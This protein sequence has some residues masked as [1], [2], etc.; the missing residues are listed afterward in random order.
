MKKFFFLVT[1]A[2]AALA[3]VGQIRHSSNPLTVNGNTLSTIQNDWPA[4]V[5]PPDCKE[6]L[7]KR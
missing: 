2:V 5:C 6:P 3:T 1:L 7:A 4:P